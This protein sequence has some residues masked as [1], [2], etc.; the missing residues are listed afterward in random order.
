MDPQLPALITAGATRNPVDAIRYL[1]ANATGATGVVIAQALALRFAVRLLGSTEAC[2]RAKLADG[3]LA[4]RE[5]TSTRDLMAKMEE[6]LR[7]RP[8]GVLIHSAAVGDYEAQPAATKLPSGQPELVLRLTPGPKIVDHVREWDPDVFLVSFKAGNPEW[9]EAKLEA[10]ARAQLARTR[11]DLVFANR[12][13]ALATS[14]LIVSET[15]TERFG[16]RDAA[17]GALVDRCRGR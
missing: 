8:G 6:E 7:A 2:L 13:G 11:S 16:S 1:S 15:T 17:I 3:S 10:V 14:C 5:Y 4:T 9:D 12:L